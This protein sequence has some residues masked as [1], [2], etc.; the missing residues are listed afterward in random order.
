[1]IEL[2]QLRRRVRALRRSL[3]LDQ[4]DQAAR[5]VSQRIDALPA[6][7]LAHRIAGY[8][9]V[10]GELDPMPVLENAL[11]FGKEVYLPVLMDDQRLM[12]AP[13]RR[14]I[15]MRP[16]RFGILEPDVPTIEWI[17]PVRLDLVLV[18]LVAFDVHGMRLGMGG[19]YYDRSFAFR[20]NGGSALKPALLG[21]AYEIQ[22]VTEL[23]RRAWDVPLDGIVTEARLYS[24]AGGTTAGSEE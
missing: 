10:D 6:F 20:M 21:L 19:G 24:G 4:R 15:P 14:D 22:K 17:M 16:N 18:P 12:F 2:P 7:A 5:R 8:L 1:M 11:T 13:F 3:P 9:A 23:E